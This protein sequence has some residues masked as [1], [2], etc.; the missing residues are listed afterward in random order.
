M[1]DN[2]QH[3]QFREINNPTLKPA[4]PAS[5]LEEQGYQSVTAHDKDGNIIVKEWSPDTGWKINEK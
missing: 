5:H 1:T 3:N 4:K 2:K